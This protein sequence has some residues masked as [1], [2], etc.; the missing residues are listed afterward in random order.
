[1]ALLDANHVLIRPRVEENYTRLFVRRMWFIKS[2]PMT[3]SKWSLDFK[4]NKEVSIAPVWVSFPGLPIPFFARNLL[5]KLA[6]VLGHLLK[7]D[8]ATGDLRRPSVARLLVELDVTQ[9]PVKKIWTG[10]LDRG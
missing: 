5:N 8:T 10:D 4:A 1:M 7:I 3:I 6:S 2:S 9:P